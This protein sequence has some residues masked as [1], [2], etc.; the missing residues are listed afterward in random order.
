VATAPRTWGTRRT[1]PN[2]AA[3]SLP[4]PRTGDPPQYWGEARPSWGPVAPGR[5]FS[6]NPSA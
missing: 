6:P 2:R 5:F 1:P 3:G 4:P